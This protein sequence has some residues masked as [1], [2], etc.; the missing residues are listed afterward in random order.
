MSSGSHD[1]PSRFKSHSGKP[2]LVGRPRRRGLLYGSLAALLL[3]AALALGL[4]LGL[5]HGHG[6]SSTTAANSSSSSGQTLPP[7]QP[8]PQ[9]NFVLDGLAGQAPRTRSYD[10]VVAQVQGA[11]D[12]V[13]KPMLVVNGMYPG[14]TIEANQGDRV[15]VN[16]TNQLENST[17]VPLSSFTLLSSSFSPSSLS[18]FTLPLHSRPHSRPHSPLQSCG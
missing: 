5:K 17:C 14:P 7:L 11:P 13:G 12:G 16:V 8:T 10:F 6:S 18:L 1:S 9:E 15:V 3:V 2:A 4:G